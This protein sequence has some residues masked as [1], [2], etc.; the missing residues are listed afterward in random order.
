M[1][2]EILPATPPVAP[3]AP[4][5]VAPVVAAPVVAP[6]TPPATPPASASDAVTFEPTGD[7]G[8]DL[9]MDFFGKLGL[10]LDSPEMQEAGNGNFS[11]L[12][13]K[14]ASLGEK[15]AGSAQYLA[16]AKEAQSRLSAQSKAQYEERRKTVHDAVG[17]EEN[18][19]ELQTY[20]NANAEPAE[21]E[22]VRTA[23]AQGGIVATA[24]AK[25]LHEMF[26]AA[27]GSTSAP[28]N[29]VQ[30]LPVPDNGAGLTLA[31][32]R[33]ELS[34]LVAKIGSQRLDGS[35]EYSALRRKYANTAS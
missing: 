4:P 17:G 32:Y 1:P 24:V 9:A 31:G 15:A 25:H 27:P 30:N 35:P 10:S 19:K 16:L 22:I 21:L 3:V 33:Q 7:A 11:Y 14:L 18:W 8:L 2:D 23:L 20:I 13:A 26:L 12:E 29:A 34:T 6:V 5:V 28:A